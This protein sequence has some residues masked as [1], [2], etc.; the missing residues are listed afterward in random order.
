MRFWQKTLLVVLILFI[1]TLDVSVIMIM[2]K[3][4]QLNM[5]REMQRSSNE[6]ALIA[7]N[8]YENL[9]SIKSR[10]MI[11]NDDVLF[12]VVRS[13]AEYYQKQDISLQ[14]WDREQ[15]VYDGAF[16]AKKQQDSAQT[17]TQE[18][19]VHEIATSVELPAP[20]QELKLVYK[21]SIEELYI[22]QKELN[23]YFV[24][25]NVIAS[26]I[27]ALFLYLLIRQLTRPLRLLSKTTQTIA[28]GNYTERVALKKN[29][30]F[31]EL[32]HNFNQMA[33]AVGRHVTELSAMAEGKQR[34]VDNLA[35][36][37]RTPLTSMQGF[38]Q[39]LN[40][41]HISEEERITASGYI[42]SG[43]LRLKS[44]VFK[45]LDLSILRR[46]LVERIHISVDELFQSVQQIEQ[47]NLEQAGMK[48]VL[49][50]S[51]DSVRGDPDLLASFLVNCINN[52]IHASAEGSEIH[53]SA[54][55]QHSAAVLEV[56]DFGKGMSERQAQRAFE[57][58]YR[59]DDAR[60]R[61]H[62][63]A[64]LGLSICKQIAEAHQASL[65]LESRENEG[66]CIRILL[67]L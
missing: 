53:L 42:W 40:S 12:D 5:E 34:I 4:W 44:L 8:I 50:N 54:Y 3:S 10:G 11:V 48:L 1:V 37:L 9:N 52:A 46:Q 45:L 47:E 27:L 41:A 62:G 28:G 35:H 29:D 51:I 38:A 2:H 56:R 14:L 26:P 43:T 21:R 16:T 63:G 32:A 64:G 49:H 59:A 20:Y 24:Y 58:F 15:I 7:N 22:S 65:S 33:E 66:T 67:G 13:Y 60:S 31:G 55:E 19:K 57:P 6:Q 30:E 61:E 18:Q 17:H 23:R 39:Y 25:I 36:E